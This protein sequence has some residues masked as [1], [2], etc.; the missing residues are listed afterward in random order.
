MASSYLSGVRVQTS[1]P[2]WLPHCSSNCVEKLMSGLFVMRCSISGWS[3]ARSCRRAS[4]WASEPCFKNACR[5]ALHSVLYSNKITLCCCRT[6][7]AIPSRWAS[8]GDRNMGFASYFR[9]KIIIDLIVSTSVHSRSLH[10]SGQFLVMS[11]E[12]RRAQIYRYFTK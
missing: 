2:P 6:E 9:Q 1:K 11:S 4:D 5:T 8:R 10:D 12:F 3:S 7:V